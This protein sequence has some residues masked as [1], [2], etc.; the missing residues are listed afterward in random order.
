M[1]TFVGDADVG[2]AVMVALLLLFLPV[3]VVG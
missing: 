2:V 3:V 1:V